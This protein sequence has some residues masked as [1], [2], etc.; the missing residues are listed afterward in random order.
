M[1]Q[2]C[3]GGISARKILIA[4]DKYKKEHEFQCPEYL[5]M[6]DITLY[7]LQ[8]DSAIGTDFYYGTCNNE[9]G[10]KTFRNIPIAICNKLEYGEIDFI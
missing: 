7:D 3:C 5:I 9:K 8:L 6:N 10:Y 2:N 4:L 1:I